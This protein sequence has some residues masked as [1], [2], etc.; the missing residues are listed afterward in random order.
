MDLRQ[1]A[2][3]PPLGQRPAFR[4]VCRSALAAASRAPG[5]CPATSNSGVAPT[6]AGSYPILLTVTDAAGAST[7]APFTLNVSALA[8]DFNYQL[9]NGKIAVPYTQK[10]RI[11]G[12]SG[13]YIVAIDGGTLPAGMSLDSK[14]LVVGG[15]PGE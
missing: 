14:S 10:L 2:L 6:A 7:S 12:G 3:H 13:A 8:F 1:A 11:T 15:T 4:P 5:S 9:T